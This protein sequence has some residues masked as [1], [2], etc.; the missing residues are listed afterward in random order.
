MKQIFTLF[1][2]FLFGI[3]LQA[4]NCV[5][6]STLANA[7]FPVQPPPYD[8]TDF[9]DGG[10][11]D[12]ACINTPFD[13]VFSAV[14]GDTFSLGIAT[15]PMDSIRIPVV[16]GIVGL[17]TGVS[18]A[19]NPP[20]CVFEKNTLGCIDLYGTITNPSLVGEY[21]LKISVQIFANGSPM[22]LNFVLPDGSFITGKY[23]LVVREESFNNCATVSSK[24]VLKDYVDTQVLPNPFSDQAILQVSSYANEELVLNIYG[25][26][27]E[28]LKTQQV[29]II[30]GTNRIEIDGSQMNSGLYYYSLSNE[31]GIISGRFS[32]VK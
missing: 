11:N 14:V 3:S 10:I 1:V 27:G 30:E 6:D 19:C 13:F 26:T 17:P 29:R 4:Q 24:N 5:P 7:D 15:V 32:I 28:I 18:Y 23:N 31:N 9:P 22:P 8:P 20:N 2:L 21:D 16:G 25:L 12:T